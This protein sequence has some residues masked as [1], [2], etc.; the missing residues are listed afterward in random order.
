M[1][2]M[3]NNA[4]L[5]TELFAKRADLMSSDVTTKRKQYTKK[6]SRRKLLELMEMFMALIVMMVSWIFTY[7]QKHQLYTVNIF[8]FLFVN[9]SLVRW[10]K[11]SECVIEP[12]LRA[13][14]H[15]S[16]RTF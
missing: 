12:P 13:E 11:K 4:E 2:H 5:Y 15:G 9:H 1:G 3:V 10:F 16:N 7:F 14:G 6:G 8:S